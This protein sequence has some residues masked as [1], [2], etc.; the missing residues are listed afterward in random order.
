MKKLYEMFNVKRQINGNIIAVKV[1]IMS[2]FTGEIFTG[3]R[4]ARCSSGDKFDL[5]YG[6]KLA[7]ERALKTALSKFVKDTKRF[8]D[9]EWNDIGESYIKLDKIKDQIR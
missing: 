5:D 8:L 4:Y 7:T 6:T 1:E 2:N 9:R 3:L